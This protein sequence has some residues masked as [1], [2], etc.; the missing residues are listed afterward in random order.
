M[1]KARK[2]IPASFI[3][4]NDEFKT[5]V[6]CHL[7]LDKHPKVWQHAVWARMWRHGNSQLVNVKSYDLHGWYTVISNENRNFYFILSNLYASSIFQFFMYQCCIIFIIEILCDLLICAEANILSLLF[8]FI[9][10]L[11]INYWYFVMTFYIN[12]P[13]SRKILLGFLLGP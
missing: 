5:T 13:R 2:N 6:K 12:L 1:K 11:S 4:R 8:F 10:F 9:I 7:V 3:I